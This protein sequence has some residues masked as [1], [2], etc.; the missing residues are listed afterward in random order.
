MEK[1]LKDANLDK[2]QIHEV[3]LVVGSTRI[4]RVQQLLQEFFDRKQLNKII[5]PD[6]AVAYGAA[7]QAAI[8]SGDQRSEIKDVL[9]LDVAPL[10]L[11]IETAGGEM[12][13]LIACN[14]RIP[15]K[16]LK[17]FTTYSDNQPAVTIQVYE[18]E[19]AMTKDNNLLARFELTGI[20]PAPRGVPKI[21]FSLDIDANGILD[22]SAKDQS[23]GRTNAITITNDTGRLSKADIDRMVAEAEKFKKEDEMQ[24]EKIAAR[25]SLES[26]VYSVKQTAEDPNVVNKLNTTDLE[27]VKEK[28]QK[29]MAWLERNSL[30]VDKEE[31]EEKQ[32]DLQQVCSPIMAKL[33]G[34]QQAQHCNGSSQNGPTVEEVD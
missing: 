1:A 29:V 4:P 21:E 9:L 14:S 20:P 22:V 2:N 19:R 31:Y 10:S 6:E 33:H 12:T 34:Q 32:R 28:T 23:T 15:T 27:T 30:Q 25:N 16:S 7:I 18:G 17:E 8:L 24:R 26:Y 3:V 5:N 11:G 13:T